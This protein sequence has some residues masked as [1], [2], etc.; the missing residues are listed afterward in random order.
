MKRLSKNLLSLFSADIARR[1]F[2]FISVAYLARVLGK[3]GFGA[4][5]LGF[6]V[7]AYV[8]VLS[9]SGFPT[10]GTKR[11][12]QGESPELVGR[13]IGSRLIT[14]IDN[15]SRNCFHS[16]HCGSEHHAC[17]AHHHIFVRCP[18]ADIFCRLVLSRERNI[19]NC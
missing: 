5:N 12:A 14:T 9:A 18:S 19:R 2:G 7:L 10:L 4:V 13:V 8:M 1:L 11:I 17:L 16:V 15:D 6:A 3:E